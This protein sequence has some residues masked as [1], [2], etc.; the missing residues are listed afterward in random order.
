M[1][2]VALGSTQQPK[3][4]AIKSAFAKI[5]PGEEI[6]LNCSKISLRS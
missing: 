4:E 3:V 6:E 5:Y 1:I 2:K